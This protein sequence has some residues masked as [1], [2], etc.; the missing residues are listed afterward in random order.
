MRRAIDA[1][2]AADATDATDA[3][4]AAAVVPS[5]AA[6]SRTER[7][8]VDQLAAAADANGASTKVVIARAEL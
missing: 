4:D 6:R 2:E 1:I 8:R 7:G 5:A 3:T